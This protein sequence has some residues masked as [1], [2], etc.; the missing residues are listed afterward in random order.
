M[1]TFSRIRTLDEIKQ[2]CAAQGVPID[3]SGHDRGD[4]HIV[5]GSKTG[6]YALYNTFNGRFFG[7]TDA[8]QDFASDDASFDDAP[9]YQ[10]LLNFFYVK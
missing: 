8:G 1:E 2:I 5:V 9:W 10:A 7:K 4:D 6:G 3:H